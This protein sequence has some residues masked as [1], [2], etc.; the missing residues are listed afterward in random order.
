MNSRPVNFARWDRLS[1]PPTQIYVNQ[2]RSSCPTKDQ[3]HHQT[4]CQL[5]FLISLA[6]QTL[7]YFQLPGE[8]RCNLLQLSPGEPHY[9]QKLYI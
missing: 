1:R 8:Y 6:Y 9:S 5:H 4:W 3:I 7:S 2:G